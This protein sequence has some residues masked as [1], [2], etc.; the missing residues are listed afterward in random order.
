M[1]NQEKAGLL[2]DTTLGYNDCLGF[3][4]GISFPFRPY[5]PK[6][7]RNLK[8]LQ[9]PLAIEDLPYFRSHQPFDE[10][11]K[12]FKHVDNHMGV[13][14]LLWHHSVFNENEFP[15]WESD[16]VKI[17]DYCKKQNAWIGSG[18]QIHEWW[19]QREKT[20]IDWEYYNAILKISHIPLNSSILLRY[21]CQILEN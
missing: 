15:G 11:L 14:T 19:T 4:W 8:V 21:M 2:Y 13:L 16:Y 7:N 17:M 18:R 6:E 10:F 3:R 1:V 12:I 5:Y 9:I 20:T